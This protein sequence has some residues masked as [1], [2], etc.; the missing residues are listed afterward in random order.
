MIELWYRFLA[1]T[2]RARRD[3][4]IRIEMQ[5]AFDGPIDRIVEHRDA[6]FVFTRYNAYA[7]HYDYGYGRAAFGRLHW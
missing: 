5:G 7:V 2:F 1:W 3:A 4:F 6:V